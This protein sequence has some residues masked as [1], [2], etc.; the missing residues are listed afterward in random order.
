MAIE[1]MAMGDAGATA[2][3]MV[4]EVC[5]R[6]RRASMSYSHSDLRREAIFESVPARTDLAVLLFNGKDA[7]KAMEKPVLIF[8]GL[9]VILKV[10]K[11]TPYSNDAIDVLVKQMMESTTKWKQ[12]FD[13]LQK[14]HPTEEEKSNAQTVADE[15]VKCHYDFVGNKTPKGHVAQYHSLAQ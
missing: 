13:I 2:I 7:R 6:R 15:A 8:D 14:E 10:N 1:S 11:N 3:V 4:G 5:G 12:F 9:R